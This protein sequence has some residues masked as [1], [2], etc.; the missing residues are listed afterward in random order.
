MIEVPVTVIRPPEL[1]AFPPFVQYN[2]E[3]P[4]LTPQQC[5]DVIA[6][7]EGK[8]LRPGTIGNGDNHSFK[9]DKDY[10]S[11][12]Q[13]SLDAHNDDIEWL[14]KIVRDRVDWTNTDHYGFDLSG[15]HEGMQYLRYDTENQGH[16]RWHQD[17][18]GGYSSHRKL[19]VVIQLSDP[20]EYE[21]CRLNMFTQEE[22]EVPTLAKGTGVIFP[23]WQPHCVTEITCGI[24]RALVCWVH[25]P[26][27]R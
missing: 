13:G 27:F 23:S 8:E 21:G 18:G 3:N 16:Y 15:L 5:D 17:Y 7:A 2:E 12:L 14:F 26:R 20:G 22:F 11:V 10:R 25:G 1:P 6:L 19:S 9:E 24:R 4:F